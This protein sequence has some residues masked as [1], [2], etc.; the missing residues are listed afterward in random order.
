MKIKRI[1]HG[2]EVEIELTSEELRS[3]RWVAEEE[4]DKQYVLD[5][6]DIYEED[7]VKAI[8]KNDA[9]VRARVAH[10]FRKY[11]DEQIDGEAEYNCFRWAVD[12]CVELGKE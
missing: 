2:E 3:A 11:M 4:Y 6:A 12:D 5:L 9:Q 1:I 8:L 7:E 10:V